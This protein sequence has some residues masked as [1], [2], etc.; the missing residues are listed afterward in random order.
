ME[1]ES[2]IFYRPAVEF[3]PETFADAGRTGADGRF[4]L[5]SVTGFYAPSGGYPRVDIT[6]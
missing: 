4:G 1:R 3:L 2:V 5:S 6:K